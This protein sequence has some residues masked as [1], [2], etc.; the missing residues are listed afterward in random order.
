MLLPYLG[1]VNKAD[2]NTGVHVPFQ[3][4]VFIFTG[5][6]HRVEFLNHITVL[7][8]QGRRFGFDPWVR[9]IPCRREWLPTSV[10]LPGESHGQKS[11]LGYLVRGVAKSRQD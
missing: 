7:R 6:I 4:S 5:C 10:F 11:L 2:I 3:I 9:K 1:F 8:L